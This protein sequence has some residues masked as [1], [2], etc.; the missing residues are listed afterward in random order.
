MILQAN[1]NRALTAALYALVA[2][3]AFLYVFI[4]YPGLASPAGMDQ[5]Q[6]ARELARGNGYSTLLLRPQA[7]RQ[8]ADS[9]LLPEK[10]ERLP[11]TFH[12]PLQPLLWAAVFKPLQAFWPADPNRTV[13]LMDRVVASIG[14]VWLV[15]TMMLAQDIARRLFDAN[16]GMLTLCSLVASS[17][18]W[19]LAVSGSPVVPLLFFTTLA[20]HL[21]TLIAGRAAGGAGVS[22]GL[23]F[24]LAI[25]V[26]GMV[27][28]HWMAW[29][30]VVGM[31]VAVSFYF[32]GQRPA[33]GAI[34]ALCLLLLGCWCWRCYTLT[35]DPLGAAKSTLLSC[36]GAESEFG[37]M[38]DFDRGAQTVF[39]DAVVRKLSRNSMEQINSVLSYLA[40]VVP[41][42]LFFLS[43]LHRF[44]RQDVQMIRAVI[45]C[46][47][48]T[49]T[50]AM[51][52]VGLPQKEMDDNQVHVVLVP[53]LA[54]FG[55]AGMA[56][57][58]ARLKPGLAGFWTQKGYAVILLVLTAWPMAMTLPQNLR[59]GLFRKN[60]LM[61]W[62]PYA[63]SRLSQ[64]TKMTT[65]N[66]AIVADAPW[67]VAWY[68]DRSSVWLPTTQL[69]FG[70]VQTLLRDHGMKVAGMLFSPW[71]TKDYTLSTQPGGE[72]SQWNDLVFRG[73]VLGLGVDLGMAVKDRLSFGVP[74]TLAGLP[75]SE[76]QMARG[77]VF[78][79]DKTGRG[80]AGPTVKA[81]P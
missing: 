27:A 52:L 57:M 42:F 2:G 9:K 16:I 5:A 71:S 60:E 28:S 19:K 69:Q 10:L 40:G 63:P 62:P 24:A 12:P 54:A 6:V 44:R 45:C 35:G 15:L 77:L 14:V 49:A 41:A 43:M 61:N 23:Y 66:E 78:Y 20:L 58:W 22:M 47:W 1:S 48:I 50:T 76:G 13:Y 4:T 8:L 51:C 25:S 64:L 30:L 53:V 36:V 26:T 17:S 81:A 79:S 34:S 29:P 72:Y 70:Q 39:L 7:L 38:R 32:P 68:A 67:S 75:G 59:I 55:M 11:E 33:V 37:V 73:P 46:M 3:L 18:M 31:L 80:Q 74:Y 21:L 56:V 65:E